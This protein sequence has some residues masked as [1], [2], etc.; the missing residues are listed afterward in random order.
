MEKSLRVLGGGDGESAVHSH[1]HSHGD[2][3]AVTSGTSLS[4]ERNDLRFRGSEK[5]NGGNSN[6]PEK[7]LAP[8]NSPSKLSAYLNLFGDFVHNM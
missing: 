4:S 6:T 1:S 2:V 3:S 8:A 7:T 5:S